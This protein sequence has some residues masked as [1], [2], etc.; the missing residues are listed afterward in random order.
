MTAAKAAPD[1]IPKMA[2]ATAALAH[3]ERQQEH[4]SKVALL[5]VI[6]PITYPAL[7]LRDEI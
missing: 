7:E 6:H 2:T 1:S 5:M 4:N 3:E